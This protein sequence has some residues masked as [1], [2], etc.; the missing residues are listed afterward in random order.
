MPHSPNE[1]WPKWFPHCMIGATRKGQLSRTKPNITG[2]PGCR[3]TRACH[4]AFVTVPPYGTVLTARSFSRSPLTPCNPASNP[5]FHAII[6]CRLLTSTILIPVS[7]LKSKSVRVF[8]TF[9]RVSRPG[10]DGV[11]VQTSI[12]HQVCFF[13]HILRFH[14]ENVITKKFIHL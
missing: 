5:V 2:G 8:S 12:L 1:T 4:V 6:R 10:P 14:R 9:G 11:M 7:P 13:T 3:P